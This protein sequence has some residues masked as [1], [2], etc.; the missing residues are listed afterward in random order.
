MPWL[1]CQEP[2]GQTF[3]CWLIVTVAGW[4]LLVYPKVSELEV[5][6][7]GN[8]MVVIHPWEECHSHYMWWHSCRAGNLILT[9]CRSQIPLPFQVVQPSTPCSLFFHGFISSLILMTI[10][11]HSHTLFLKVLWFGGHKNILI[12]CT[13]ITFLKFQVQLFLLPCCFL[14]QS[15]SSRNPERLS[16]S[17]FSEI[18]ISKQLL[19]LSSPLQK[20]QI[21]KSTNSSS[22]I[23]SICC[24]KTIPASLPLHSCMLCVSIYLHAFTH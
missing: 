14:L 20:E 7:W 5:G 21:Y 1:S 13:K 17:F 9:T 19:T 10:W 11:T 8:I 18:A 4:V 24:F 3:C 2:K 16:T 22:W 12:H 23:G 15:Y 6:G